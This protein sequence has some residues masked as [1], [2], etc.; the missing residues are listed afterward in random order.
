MGKG[1]VGE[2]EKHRLRPITV[3]IA[4]SARLPKSVA[5]KHVFGHLTIELEINPADSTIVD[6]SCALSPFLGRKILHNALFEREIEGA[7]EDAVKQL[8]ERFSG[9]T[10]KATIAALWDAYRRYKEFLEESKS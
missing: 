4:G 7:I 3:V 9:I 2:R 5:A 1:L 6:I 10:K 8:E